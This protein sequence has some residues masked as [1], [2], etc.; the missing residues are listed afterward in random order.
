M[1]DHSTEGAKDSL[2]ADLERM[3]E[4]ERASREILDVISESR[5]DEMPVL[6]AIVRNAARLCDAKVAGLS[7]VNE[8]RTRMRYAAIFG[9]DKGIFLPGYEFDLDGPLQVA[10]T[11]EEARTIHTADLADDV[12]YRERNPIRVKVVEEAGVRTFLTVP[13][14]KAGLAFGCLNL[15]RSEVR[16]F[17]DDDIALIETFA[18]QAVIAIENV[19]QF[20]ELQTRLEREAASREIL[21]V[22]STSR[23]DTAPVFEVILR[24]AAQLC[25]APM[26][27]MAICNTDQTELVMEAHW[28]ES[29]SHLV[30]DQTA[31]P[32][33]GPTANATSVREQRI[34]HVGDL[35]DTDAYRDGDPG[36]V[37]AVDMEGIRTFLAVPLLTGGLAIGCIA[38][39]RREVQPFDDSQIELVKSFAAQAVI[40]IE[41]VRQFREVQE[42]LEREAAT[43]DILS[44][45]SRSRDNETPVFDAILKNAQALCNTPMSALVLATAEDDYQTLAAHR[46]VPPASVELHA[47]RQVPVEPDLSY[48]ARAIVDGKPIAFADFG[49]TELYANNSPG[50]RSLVDASGVGSVLFMPL[51]RDDGAIGCIALFRGGVD[52]FDDAEIALIET[53]AAQ[54]VIAIENVRQ[55]R[56]LRT[57]LAHEA[58][59][60]EILEVISQSRDD[61]Q[62]VFDAI[63]KRAAQ[64]CRAP[65]AGLLMPNDS[66]THVRYVASWGPPL[67]HFQVGV[68]EWSIDDPIAVTTAIRE[69]RVVNIPDLLTDDLTD[70]K[71][72]SRLEII[73]KEGIRSVLAVPLIKDGKAIGCFDVYRLEVDPFTEDEVALIQSFAAQ[74]VIAI[75]NVRQFKALETLNAELGDRVEEQVGE[76][77]RMGKLKRF[78]PTAVADTVMSS[79]S[80]ELLKSHR[81]MLGVL[82]CDIRGFT[83][84]C[85]T[86]EPEETIEVLQTYHEEMGKLINASSAG[87]DQR[88]GDGIMVLFNDPVPSDD[89][90]GSAVQLAIAMRERMAELCAD[91]KKL[92]HRLGFGVGVSLGY[93]TVGIVG[94]EGRIDYS[95]SGTAINLA[96]RL[97]DEASDGEILLSPR[98]RI[99]VEDDFQVELRDEISFKGIRE[100]VEVFKLTDAAAV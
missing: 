77:E 7:L 62:P 44:V 39:Y 24:N 17:S 91:W 36:R 53:F 90:A 63:L 54:A 19:R 69:S 10:Q 31:W 70:E 26:A 67:K 75:E 15:N 6:E 88:V 23:A 49:E 51:M 80:E 85:E 82:M 30:V 34:V 99:S 86:A 98:A 11:V 13:L 93:A 81:V 89:P 9:A 55:F 92:G 96:A 60:R 45:I 33:D 61:H 5:A 66:Q 56:E 64:L 20:R 78:L 68:S 35:K 40:A 41:N 29:L 71:H 42:R 3:R 72:P 22:I 83:A 47:K 74:A 57:R 2:R 21:E 8:G 59:T 58:A 27:G 1:H 73:Q 79:G 76:I 46:G 52:P 12:L 43:S 100:P 38:L 87:V 14:I 37:E 25:S 16:P 84:F 97:C 28:G 32:M 94:F 48:V 18:E 65:Q 4:R 95:A 50:M